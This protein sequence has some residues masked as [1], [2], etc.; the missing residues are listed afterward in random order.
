MGAKMRTVLRTSGG[1]SAPVA[2]CRCGLAAAVIAVSAPAA[3]AFGQDLTTLLDSVPALAPLTDGEELQYGDLSAFDFDD[4]VARRR[5]ITVPEDLAI[6]AR[7]ASFDD[8]AMVDVIGLPWSA[9]T[10]AISFGTPSAVA[11]VYG[12]RADLLASSDMGPALTAAGFQLA[13]RDGVPV[14]WWL[15]D[16]EIDFADGTTANPFIGRVPS[17]SRVA[18]LDDRIAHTRVWQTLDM[19]LATRDDRLPSMAD[20]PD[21]AALAAAFANHGRVVQATITATMESQADRN[22]MAQIQALMA[23]PDRTDIETV[24]PEGPPAVPPYA[25]LGMADLDRAS[26]R[27]GALGLVYGDEET[28]RRAADILDRAFDT[29]IRPTDGHPVSE[30]LTEGWQTV[31]EPVE[32]RVAVVMV[33]PDPVG[34]DPPLNAFAYLRR[35]YLNRDLPV[36]VT[37]WP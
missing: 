32:D 26:G 37:S 22:A 9:F 10:A 24:V 25:V 33:F 8:A 2:A 36:V 5:L 18:V 16:L 3:P 23:A 12:V 28:A 1:S 30:P 7:T 4:P 31:V 20:R 17:S 14:F 13:D 19:I 21:V 11:H 35:L 15:E 29:A 34:A 27:A 6:A